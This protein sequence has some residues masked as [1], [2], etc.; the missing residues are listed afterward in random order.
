MLKDKILGFGQA[1]LG[2][3][4][5]IVVAY[6]Y[7]THKIAVINT[8]IISVIIISIANILFGLYIATTSKKE[9]KEEENNE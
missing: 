1:I 3:G 9:I 5:L 2:L 7:F 6:C 8:T 4:M